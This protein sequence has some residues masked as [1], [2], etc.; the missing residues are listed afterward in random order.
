MAIAAYLGTSDK[1]DEGG[2]HFTLAYAD[3]VAADFAEYTKAIASGS[4][5]VERPGVTPTYTVSADVKSGF[6]V[7]SGVADAPG[8]ESS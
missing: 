4:V 7:T 3:Q 6:T 2:V 8:P 1:F 5:S